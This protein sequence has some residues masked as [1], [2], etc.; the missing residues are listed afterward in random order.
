[1]DWTQ[2][3]EVEVYWRALENVEMNLGVSYRRRILDYVSYRWLVLSLFNLL[4]C[5]QF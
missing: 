4:L 2:L 5:K 3:A 1:M